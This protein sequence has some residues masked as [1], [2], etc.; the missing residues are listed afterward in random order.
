[1]VTIAGGGEE[2]YPR[3]KEATEVSNSDSGHSVSEGR[4][5]F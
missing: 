2:W 4:G 3:E 1:M 5:R